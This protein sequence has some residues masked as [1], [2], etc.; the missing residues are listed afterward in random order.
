VLALA[1]ASAFVAAPVQAQEDDVDVTTVPQ[2]TTATPASG[3]TIDSLIDDAGT[4]TDGAPTGSVVPPTVPALRPSLGATSLRTV[5]RPVPPSRS[6]KLPVVPPSLPAAS[7]EADARA[8]YEPLGLRLGGLQVNGTATTGI[9]MLRHSID[10]HETFVRSS[11][12][13]TARTDWDG[14]S[15]E[16]NLGGAF[17]RSLNG[18]DEKLPE[19]DARLS[20]SFDV[21]NADRL[22]G[23]VGWTL[24]DDDGKVNT[25]S[26]T[27][28]YER[29]GG[30]VGLKSSLGV[31]REVKDADPTL[32]N[33]ALSSSLRLS[34]ATGAIVEPFVE[35]GAFTRRF[36]KAAAGDGISRNGLGGEAKAGVTIN[37]D[38]LRG[39][40]ALGYGYERLDDAALADISGLIG[41]ASMT[42]DAT[43]LLSLSALASTSFEP[44]SDAGAS[45]ILKHSGDIG[46]T[47]A[48][49]PNA[50]VTTGA[51]L[52]YEDYAGI[53]RKVI[54]TSLKAGVGYRFNRSVEV[55]LDG[56]HK[57]VRSSEDGGDYNESTVTATLTLRR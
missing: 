9:G 15:V 7:R 21:T 43:E 13:V 2:T 49:A 20:A 36:D 1:V 29:F 27:I 56:E 55:G 41:S 3:R 6:A 23:A 30:L 4:S 8:E 34:L 40:L 53:D 48:L 45:G 54:T 44:T 46:V 38:T 51:E 17:R 31:D 50:F 11:A 32:D 39:E 28:G 18:I 16:L 22:S 26:G 57:I 24:R 35:F 10:G 5:I 37:R 19:G 52:T 47:Y 12:G 33:T 25:F 14:N 42:W